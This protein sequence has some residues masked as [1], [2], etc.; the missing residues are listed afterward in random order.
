MK[1]KDTKNIEDIF[2]LTPMQEGM[3]FH[4]LKDPQGDEYFEQLSLKLIIAIN[5]EIFK[6]AWNFVIASNEALRVVFRWEKMSEPVQMVM[7][8]NRLGLRYFDLSAG[9]AD[10]D[11]KQQRLA[12]LKEKDRREKFDLRQTPFRVTLCKLENDCYE[13]IISHHHILYDGWSN[14]ILLKEFFNAYHELS[15]G[16][17]PSPVRKTGFKE[18]VKYILDPA[19]DQRE[20]DEFWKGYLKNFEG[21]TELSIKKKGIEKNHEAAYWQIHIPANINSKLKWLV[22]EYKLTPAVVF[23]TVWGLLL[24]GYNDCEDV[25]FGA[26]VSGRTPAFKGIEDMVGLFINTLPLRV[27]SQAE[28]KRTDLLFEIQ[29]DFH[30]REEFGSTPLVQVKEYSGIDPRQELFDTLMVVE[31]YPLDP[32][33]KN[34]QMGPQVFFHSQSAVTHY[35]LTVA[36]TLGE[37][38]DI[39]F[40]YPAALFEHDMIERMAGHFICILEEVVTNPEKKLRD[41]DCLTLIE[42]R[43]LLAEFNNTNTDFPDNKTIP[44]LFTDQVEK[45]PDHVALI[46]RETRETHEKFSILPVLS[47]RPVCLSYGEL[48]EKTT[49]L[50]G[51]LIDKGVKADSI[52][53]VMLGRSVEMTVAILGILKAGGAYLPVDPAYPEERKQYMLKDSNALLLPEQT[54]FEIPFHHSS[55][56][57]HHSSHLAYVIYTSGSTGKPKGVMIEHRSAVNLLY[58]VQRQYPFTGSDVYLLK[59]SYTFDVSVTELFGWYM[60][61]GKLAILGKNEEK[62]PRIICDCIQRYYVTHIN[63]VPSMFNAFLECLEGENK[64]RLSSLKYIFLAGETLL[65]ETVKKFRDLNTG[66]TLENIYGPTEGTVYASRYSMLA[67]NGTG[68]VPI[69]KPLPNIKLYILNKYNH[70][71]PLGITGELYISGNGLARGYLNRPELSAEKFRPPIPPIPQMTQMKNKKSALRSNFHHS[72]F[73]ISHIQHSIF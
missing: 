59:T 27:Q 28:K 33:L 19:R 55:F 24:Q 51:L 65:T 16:K 71:Q 57:L 4:Y 37:E 49:N 53:A 46:A 10:G 50:A 58:A 7:K 18:F 67:W 3:L 54:F 72:A 22:R 48:N 15:R 39:I 73:A 17:I 66:I 45:T 26:T 21:P 41:I 6:Q 43:L 30:R 11:E 62:D 13:M 60:G 12:E 23:Y 35:D 40:S 9:D 1:K 32:L 69:G 31:N 8:E 2:A 25:I 61:G 68:N 44:E 38:I 63:F 52:V 5:I 70:M 47:V 36:V 29:Q 14:G 64:R 20:Q 42:K 56:N 34:G